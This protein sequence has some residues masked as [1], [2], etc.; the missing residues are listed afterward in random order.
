M[1][2][3]ESISLGDQSLGN[4]ALYSS[5]VSKKPGLFPLES[6]KEAKYFSSI[7][8]EIYFG[9]LYID[10]V[11]E[12]N[13]QLQQ[14]TMPLFGYNSYVY[15]DIALGSRIIQGQF[16]INFTK[17]GYMYEILETLNNAQ[18]IEAVKTV[19]VNGVNEFTTADLGKYKVSNYNDPIVSRKTNPLWDCRFSIVMSYGNYGSKKSTIHAANSTLIA[20][21]GVQITGCMQQL[22]ING[23]PVLEVYSFTARDMEFVPVTSQATPAVTTPVIV[24]DSKPNSLLDFTLKEYVEKEVKYEFIRGA[25][26]IVDDYQDYIEG[27]FNFEF[28]TGLEITKLLIKPELGSNQTYW[29]DFLEIKVVSKS[30]ASIAIDT[31]KRSDIKA[32]H[33]NI[34]NYDPTHM[35]LNVIVYHKKDGAEVALAP[36]S[37]TVTVDPNT[38]FNNL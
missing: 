4:K 30:K 12:I 1:S 21:E 9:D 7:D 38:F 18:R 10:D 34:F 31:K 20:L 17:A 16:A 6:S 5:T 33:K 36:N 13:F 37:I 22:D 32:W 29:T 35:K 8:A 3:F 28:T 2:N 25:S 14:N 23:S 11:T 24:K 26:P 19:S 27:R 15:D